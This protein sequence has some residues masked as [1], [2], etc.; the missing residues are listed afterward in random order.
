MWSMNAMSD[1]PGARK[2]VH[3][4]GLWHRAVMCWCSTR[5]RGVSPEAFTEKGHRRRQVDSSS[6][7]IW[8]ARG[9]R[10]VRAARVREEIGLHLMQTPQRLFKIDACRRRLGVLL[11]YRCENEGV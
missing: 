1:W 9:L 11:V 2:E 4:R 10:R 6:S 7:G 3:A 8:T 5:A